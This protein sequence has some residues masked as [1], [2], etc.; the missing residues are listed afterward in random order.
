MRRSLGSTASWMYLV[1]QV[2]ACL[3]LCVSL[4]TDKSRPYTLA[5]SLLL[6][7]CV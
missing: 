7:T 4:F 3:A 5:E 6:L 2:R 1:M